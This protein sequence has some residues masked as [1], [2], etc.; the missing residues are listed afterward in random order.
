M[1]AH[2][3][4]ILFAHLF[5]YVFPDSPLVA[6]GVHAQRVLGKRDDNLP[7]RVPY[8]FP[9]PGSDPVADAFRERRV[10]GTLLDLDG[11]LC[12]SLPFLS[13]RTFPTDE[14]CFFQRSSRLNAEAVASGWNSLFS[15]IRDNNSIPAD[16]REL[17]ILR[18]AV[19]NGAAYQWIQHEPEG[20][21]AGLTTAQLSE[22]RN[23]PPLTG[24][25]PSSTTPI[26]TNSNLTPSQAA[27]LV[28]ADF[29]TKEVKVP[30]SVFDSLKSFLSD[31]QMVEAVATVGGYNFVSRFVVALDVDGKMD[32]PVPVPS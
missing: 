1:L 18:S 29:V 23:L 9:A 14:H 7:A 11:V 20:R 22:I 25:S 32:T 16:L 5:A 26:G 13:R 31:R 15:V 19:L 12:A 30:T 2:A 8:V 6:P 4:L 21:A 10:N 27:A 28:F 24:S 17:L 3:I